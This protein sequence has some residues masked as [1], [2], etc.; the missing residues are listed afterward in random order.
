[1][2]NSCMYLPRALTMYPAC[3]KIMSLC[4]MINP[5]WRHQME[6]LSALLALCVGNSPVTGEFPAQGPVTRSFGVFS[7][8]LLNKRCSKQAGDSRRHGTHYDVIEWHY[9]FVFDVILDCYYTF[10]AIGEIAF[11]N[12]LKHYWLQPQNYFATGVWNYV[13]CQ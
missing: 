4:E 6:K 1:M 2:S 9:I 11:R 10:I 3:V 13:L 7:D 5:W 12:W 8:L